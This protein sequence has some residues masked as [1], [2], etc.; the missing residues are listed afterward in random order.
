[1]VLAEVIPVQV[2]M[3][4]KPPPPPPPPPLVLTT[5]SGSKYSAP[6]PASTRLVPTGQDTLH[7]FQRQSIHLLTEL[8]SLKMKAMVESASGKVAH[9]FLSISA[10]VGGVCV[11]G[12]ALIHYIHPNRYELS[13]H[14]PESKILCSLRMLSAPIMPQNIP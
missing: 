6:T 3:Q 10:Q 13:I 5:T 11:W 12:G 9:R 2:P 1:M 7:K 4:K 14:N 8:L